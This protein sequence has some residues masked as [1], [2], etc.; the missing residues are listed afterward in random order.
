MKAEPCSAYT[1]RTE[2]PRFH[3][4]TDRLR[5]ARI[6]FIGVTKFV[7]YQSNLLLG[8]G[9]PGVG[10]VVHCVQVNAEILQENVNGEWREL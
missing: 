3:G 8:E 5:D 4:C 9:E 2:Q 1:V 7:K 6:A 10:R